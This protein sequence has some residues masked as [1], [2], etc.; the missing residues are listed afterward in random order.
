MKRFNF[1]KLLLG[2][3][4]AIAVAGIALNAVAATMPNAGLHSN[5]LLKPVL[6][7]F[8]ENKAPVVQ[9][10]KEHP[11]HDDDS[12]A[13]LTKAYGMMPYNKAELEFEITLPKDW[14][15]ID[16]PP[17]LQD[18]SSQAIIGDLARYTS[19][20]I[21]T[22]QVE[23]IV[24]GI[25]LDN[26]IDARSWLKNY[27]LSSGYSMQGE[28]TSEGIKNAAGLY[29]AAGIA[30]GTSTIEYASA[31]ISGS[32]LLLATFK[33]PLSLQTYVKFL[34][35]K[36][37]DSFRIL[38]P[39]DDPIED[40]KVFTLVDSIKFTYPA[41]WEVVATDFR[42]MNKLT[43]HLQTKSLSKIIDGFVRFVAVRRTRSTDAKTEI[44][45][46]KK[47]FDDTMKLKFLKMLSTGK[48]DAYDR[49]I[50][51][52][53]EVYDV[54]NIKGTSKIQEIHMAMLGDK[55]WYI[56]AFMFT[57]K[58]N[59]NLYA[60]ARNVQTFHEILKSIK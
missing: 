3:L 2:G 35:K 1:Q 32:Y 43:A 42:D 45:N 27:M 39:K 55:D 40:Q 57:P 10:P 53:Y 31:H 18:S 51:N 9:A 37:I 44:E 50:F 11:I 22:Q 23:V 5:P 19:P 29:V 21:G 46:Q 52:R 26:E 54:Q 6:F 34:Q 41:S 24:Q 8:G 36:S 12:F 14:T 58:E 60:W 4:A 17:S 20:M 33:A 15:E 30:G 13:K 16:I 38:Y 25:H 56:F 28:V 47:Y 59:D 49:F 7:G 48:S